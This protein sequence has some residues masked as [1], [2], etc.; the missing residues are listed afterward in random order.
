MCFFYCCASAHNIYENQ[1]NIYKNNEVF[2]VYIP[3]TLTCRFSDAMHVT[4]KMI[5]SV[6]AVKQ[7]TQS[8]PA[9]VHV[10]YQSA[11]IHYD[12]GQITY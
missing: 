4:L 3:V 12:C 2:S 10:Q 5:Y 7:L 11:Y 1:L 6:Y 9:I 8:G